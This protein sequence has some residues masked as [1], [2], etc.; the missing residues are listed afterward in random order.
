MFSSTICG[1]RDTAATVSKVRPWPACTS[2]PSSVGKAR[3]GGDAFDLTGDGRGVALK[4]PLAIGAGVQLDDIG[5]DALGRLDCGG[6][7]LDEQR[8]AHAGVLEV[9]D[10]TLQSGA[11]AGNVEAAFG[12]ALLAPLGD[13]AAG[14]RKVPQR[15]GEH[16]LGRCH[17]QIERAR[18]LALEARDVVVGDVAA[19]FAQVRGDAVGAGLDGQVRG[20]Q[21]IGMP[22]AARV[23]DGGDVVDVHAQAEIGRLTHLRAR[24]ASGTTTRP[25][26]TSDS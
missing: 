20:A 8:D 16:L 6:I 17:L 9:A 5:A 7:G 23:A 11:A 4:R 26:P 21:R 1:R 14:V 3:G 2:S 12:R 15:D 18:Q 19:V 22:A 10:D 13:E 25:R 24:K